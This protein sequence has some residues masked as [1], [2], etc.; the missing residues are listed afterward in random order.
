MEEADVKATSVPLRVVALPLPLDAC[1]GG[2]GCGSTRGY[3]DSTSEYEKRRDAEQADHMTLAVLT[4][5]GLA[6]CRRPH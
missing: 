5:D 2:R 3:D 6:L 4:H 1:A